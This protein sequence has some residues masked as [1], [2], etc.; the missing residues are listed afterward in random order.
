MH[1]VPVP[2]LR[3]LLPATLFALA[4]ALSCRD[5][6]NEPKRASPSPLLPG[7]TGKPQ[8][9]DSNRCDFDPPPVLVVSS[10]YVYLDDIT[11]D[12]DI[13]ELKL[14]DLRNLYI[15]VGARPRRDIVVQVA[16]GV[17][18][19]GVTRVLARARAAGFTDVTQVD[20]FDSNSSKLR[21][22]RNAR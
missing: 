9:K 16:K 15:Q 4:L 20:N 19:D 11:V 10:E 17:R 1:C 2:T 3:F 12:P 13:L 8:A 7:T 5:R 18:P 22:A 6:P 21:D 14:R